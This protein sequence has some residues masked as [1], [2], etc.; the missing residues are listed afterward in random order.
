MSEPAFQ[1]VFARLVTDPDFRDRIRS[2]GSAALVSADFQ[3]SR[4]EMSDLVAVARSPGIDVMRT[5]HKGFRMNKL[6][7]MLPLTCRLLGLTRLAREAGAFWAGRPASS[8]YYLEEAEA[9]ASFLERRRREGL[10]VPYLAEVLAYERAVMCLRKPRPAQAPPPRVS[11]EFRH[12][13]ALL[14]QAV[15]RGERPCRI[16]RLHACLIGELDPS[17]EPRW[18]LVRAGLNGNPEKT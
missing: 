5:L 6:F 10:R 3:L 1:S 12:N 9:F 7:S 11:V 8:F 14:L 4:K 13:P 18:E 15:S 16:P 2:R 17:G